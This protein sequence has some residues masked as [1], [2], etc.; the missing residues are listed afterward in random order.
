MPDRWVTAVATHP[1]EPETAYVIFSGY[2]YGE[3][4]GHVFQTIDGG[5]S[6]TDVSI[7]LPEVPVN[8][9]IIDPE[10]PE[11]LYLATDVGVYFSLNEGND[12]AEL[13]TGLPN[14]VINDIVLHNPTRKLVAGTYG[15]SM[16][17]ILLEEALETEEVE[18][19]DIDLKIYPNPVKDLTAIS[20]QL[21]GK[22]N[23]DISLFNMN[24]QL[25]QH[26]FKGNINA[27]AH[28]YTLDL[29]GY[30]KG[31]YLCKIKIDNQS[32]GRRIVKTD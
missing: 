28:N 22:A 5:A 9:I 7:D 29:G 27:G 12:W 6:W 10:H 14:V 30:P 25:V 18:A 13:G 1:I 24:G 2:R 20:F 32:I 3:Y 31:H 16:Y 15:R 21:K 11:W 19:A 4:M 26:I 17:S 23:T 8:D